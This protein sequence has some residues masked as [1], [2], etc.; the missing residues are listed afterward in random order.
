MRVTSHGGEIDIPL[1]QPSSGTMELQLRAHRAIAAGAKS[2]SVAL[3]Q[4]HAGTS[5]PASLAVLA[6]DNVELIPNK[7]A[8]EGLVQQRLAPAMKL[9]E[10]QQDPLFYRGTMGPADVLRP[11]SACT[12]NESRLTWPAE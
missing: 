3:P 9:P 12:A 5:S 6:A 8:I 11:T 4:P 2:L 7:Q 1:V 10:R